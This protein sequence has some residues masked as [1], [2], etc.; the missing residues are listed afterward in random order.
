MSRDERAELAVRQG[1]L[2]AALVAGA[3]VPDGF[4]AADLAV[5]RRAL[6][7]KRAGEVRRYWPLL[8]TAFA[9]RWGEVF[10]A[11]AAG[12]A[13]AGALRDGWDL[14]RHLVAGASM[15]ASAAAE[16]AVR[17]ACQRYDGASPPRTRR[18]PAVRRVGRVAAIQAFGHVR[19]LDRASTP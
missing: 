13:P 18:L 2:V 5:A 11:W 19:V 16:L 6:L 14:A 10:A 17:E 1:A 15:P 9:D 3:P 7:R 8:A 4:D 12:R